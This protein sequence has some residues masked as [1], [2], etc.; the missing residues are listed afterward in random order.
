MPGREQDDV[1]PVSADTGFLAVLD[2]QGDELEVDSQD[3]ITDVEA[4]S[5]LL[6]VHLRPP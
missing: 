1:L 3:G 5:R 2:R 4:G 6:Y